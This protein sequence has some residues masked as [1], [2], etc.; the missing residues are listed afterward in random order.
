[1]RNLTSTPPKKGYKRFDIFK[2]ENSKLK[3]AGTYDAKK[4][5]DVRIYLAENGFK[6]FYMWA[7]RTAWDKIDGTHLI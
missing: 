1:M 6:G 3:Y 5:E 2:V 4:K 7:I